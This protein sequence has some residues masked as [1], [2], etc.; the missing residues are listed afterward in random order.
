MKP[1]TM[2][3]VAERARSMALVQPVFDAGSYGSVQVMKPLGI[4]RRW[5]ADQ[6]LS[7]KSLQ[8]VQRSARESVVGLEGDEICGPFLP[9]VWQIAAVDP[10]RLCGIKGREFGRRSSGHGRRIRLIYTVVQ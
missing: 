3:K 8:V 6:P 9:P 1:L 2:F 10:D 5:I 7:A 4:V